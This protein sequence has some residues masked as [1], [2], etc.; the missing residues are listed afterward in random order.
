NPENLVV[1]GL[2]SPTD[3]T[4]TISPT[5]NELTINLVP[6]SANVKALAGDALVITYNMVLTE[7]AVPDTIKVRSSTPVNKHNSLRLIEN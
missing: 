7:D 4:V 1:T 5:R 3:Y 2:T 6:G